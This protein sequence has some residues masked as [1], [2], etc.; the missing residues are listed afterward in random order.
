LEKKTN[1]WGRGNELAGRRGQIS[2][3]GMASGEGLG[4]N[5]LRESG[6]V[7]GERAER[8]LRDAGAVTTYRTLSN[9]E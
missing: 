6:T 7:G 4:E 3:L 2:V 9:M 1:A 5:E 8:G